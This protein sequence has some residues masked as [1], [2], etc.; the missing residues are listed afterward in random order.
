ML[1]VKEQ[2][3]ESLFPEARCISIPMLGPLQI[4]KTPN[5]KPPNQLVDFLHAAG[6][7]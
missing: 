3:R 4:K 2:I 5:I 7:Q 6:F 1:T